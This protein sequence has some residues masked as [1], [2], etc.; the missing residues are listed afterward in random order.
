MRGSIVHWDGRHGVIRTDDGI[1]VSFFPV[2]L[3]A[4][5]YTGQLRVGDRIYFAASHNLQGVLL[6]TDKGRGFGLGTE[7]VV[8]PCPIGG[9]TLAALAQNL[10]RPH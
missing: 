9:R 10:R 4:N 8:F 3:A 7:L 2:H 1:E 6:R 5:C